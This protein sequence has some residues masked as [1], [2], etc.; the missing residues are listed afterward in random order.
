MTTRE[1]IASVRPI[2]DIPLLARCNAITARD[3]G[4]AVLTILMTLVGPTGA[5]QAE[6]L[7][8]LKLVA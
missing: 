7:D 1:L 8:V 6:K 2:T 5:G 3:A 4:M